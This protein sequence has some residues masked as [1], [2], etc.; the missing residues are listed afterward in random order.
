MQKTLSLVLVYVD[1][2]ACGSYMAMATLPLTFYKDAQHG[3]PVS[4]AICA[5]VTC[6][7]AALSRLPLVDS[8][9]FCFLSPGLA[10]AL[11]GVAAHVPDPSLLVRLQRAC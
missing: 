2:I 9:S 4:W 5:G 8:T 3:N 10:H 11:Y 6:A 1:L 7:A